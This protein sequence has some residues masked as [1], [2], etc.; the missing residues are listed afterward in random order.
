MTQPLSARPSENQLATRNSSQRPDNCVALA[1]LHAGFKGLDG[2][3][4]KDVDTLLTHNSPG[5]VLGIHE[6]HRRTGLRLTGG[7]H[8][9]EHQIPE[10]TL[11]AEFGEE[12][13]MGVQ[14]PTLANIWAVL[15]V[16]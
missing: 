3:F 13:R 15:L 1:R 14:D 16:T 5:V 9:F 6:M 2:V 10:H 11:P 12:R 7:Q 4:G 8:R